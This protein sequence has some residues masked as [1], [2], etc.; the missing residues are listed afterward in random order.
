MA[1]L[2]RSILGAAAAASA[3]VA[4]AD[5]GAQQRPVSGARVTY[6]THANHFSWEGRHGGFHG[7]GGGVWIVE[8]EVPVIVEREVVREVPAAAPATPAPPASPRKAYVIGASYAALPG[9]CM[10]WIEDGAS[11]Y[12][13]GGGEWYRQLGKQYRAV[14]RP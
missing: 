6:P 4:A 13:C 2:H 10:K 3:F 8:R 12:Y 7:A 5:A 1:N 11:Y 9:G 14:A